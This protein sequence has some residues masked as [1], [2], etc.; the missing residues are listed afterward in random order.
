MRVV[1]QMKLRQLLLPRCLRALVYDSCRSTSTVETAAQTELLD[2]TEDEPNDTVMAAAACMADSAA[3]W[4]L[5]AEDRDER[6]ECT[7][8]G[9]R[10]A[11]SESTLS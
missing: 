5:T 10:R 8:G 3:M 7:S 4:R 6:M 9:T 2:A 11:H 1:A